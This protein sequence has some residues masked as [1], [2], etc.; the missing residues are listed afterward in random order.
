MSDG[1]GVLDDEARL[2]A[3]LAEEERRRHQRAF[4]SLYPDE[5]IRDA[6]GEVAEIEVA[7]H[8]VPL[9]ARSLYTKH[10]EYFRVSA[11][12]REVGMVAAN[13]VGK[14]FCGTFADAAH[15]TGRY[16][17]WWDGRRFPKPIRAW[18]AGK[19]YESTQ[20]ILQVYLLGQVLGSGPTKRV[21][22]TGMIPG[23][24]IDME[25]VSWRQGVKDMVDTVRV[26]HAS[27][28][29]STLGLKS[30]QQGRGAFEGTAQHLIHLDEEPPLD[31]YGEC[32]TRTATTNGLLCTTWTPLDGQ[33]ETVMQF[34]PKDL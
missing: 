34:Y 25:T 22:G 14:S 3:A 11:D 20:D 30:Y 2:L 13:R 4:F 10:L 27:G 9:Y 21:S 29:W 18:V 19:T 32:L 33:T 15:L 1:V 7:G 24:L 26:K 16:P 8:A 17:A 12:Y 31:I 6:N 5:T 28:G 23:G